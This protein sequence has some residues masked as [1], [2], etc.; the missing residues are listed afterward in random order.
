MALRVDSTASTGIGRQLD[1]IGARTEKFDTTLTAL[2][3]AQIDVEGGTIGGRYSL[4]VRVRSIEWPRRRG[5]RTGVVRVL[6][7]EEDVG[8]QQLPTLPELAGH[9]TQRDQVESSFGE[10]DDGAL[11]MWCE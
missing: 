1:R 10:V 11:K 7:E 9:A 8:E 4:V 3:D 2:I 6:E 5:T